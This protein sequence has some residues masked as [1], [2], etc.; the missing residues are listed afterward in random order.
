MRNVFEITDSMINSFQTNSI[1]INPTKYPLVLYDLTVSHSYSLFKKLSISAVL[2]DLKKF[3]SKKLI[4]QNLKSLITSL[5]MKYII[6][7]KYYSKLGL[8]ILIKFNLL[9]DFKRS[10]SVFLKT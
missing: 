8:K 7:N 2:S 4:A 6:K 5:T 10:L 9:I 1:K 3:K